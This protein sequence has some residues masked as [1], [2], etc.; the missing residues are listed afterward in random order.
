[1][2]D[3]NRYLKMSE[4]D[5]DMTEYFNEI[6]NSVVINGVETSSSI[7]N[8]G[9]GKYESSGSTIELNYSVI[10]NSKHS[11]QEVHVIVNLMKNCLLSTD[12]Y[13]S[14]QIDGTT[15]KKTI[16]RH[17]KRAVGVMKTLIDS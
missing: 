5:R 6:A 15:Y 11:L 12:L 17:C 14:N 8:P 13:I 2:I 9:K 3:L 7:K 4:I 10:Q 1:M 16:I